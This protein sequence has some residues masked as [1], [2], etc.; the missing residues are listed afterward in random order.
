MD[1]LRLRSEHGEIASGIDERACEAKVAQHLERAIDRKAFGAAAKLD[2]DIAMP[3][4]DGM[5]I[6]QFDGIE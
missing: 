6:Q 3:K 4:A 1:G 2:P 5:P